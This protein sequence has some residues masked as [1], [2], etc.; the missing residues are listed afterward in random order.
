MREDEEEASP[1]IEREKEE[2]AN[3]GLNR[4]V[5]ARSGKVCASAAPEQLLPLHS[6]SSFIFLLHGSY[7]IHNISTA[8][9]SKF[10]PPDVRNVVIDR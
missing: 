6:F 7:K 8:V 2:R 3:E 9:I 5:S 1:G 4:R 10:R